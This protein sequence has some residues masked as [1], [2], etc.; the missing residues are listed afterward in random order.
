[1]KKL[2]RNYIGF[3]IEVNLTGIKFYIPEWFCLYSAFSC[4][5]DPALDFG[6]YSFIFNSDQLTQQKAH[7]LLAKV[8]R[9]ETQS[10]TQSKWV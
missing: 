4:L 8:L 2:H 10:K 9:F 6:K 5:F 1:M 3:R 7:A